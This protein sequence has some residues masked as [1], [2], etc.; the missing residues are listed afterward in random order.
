MKK[1]GYIE[2]IVKINLNNV[3]FF[4][5]IPYRQYYTKSHHLLHIYSLNSPDG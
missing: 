1:F 2:F 4:I 3:E 5:P